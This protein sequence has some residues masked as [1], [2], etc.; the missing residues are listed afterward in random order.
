MKVFSQQLCRRLQ[1]VEALAGSSVH[2]CLEHQRT[3]PSQSLW[4]LE[5]NSVL[6]GGWGSPSFF[7]H[8]LLP[9]PVNRI[10]GQ[11][12]VHGGDIVW[13]RAESEA[14]SVF[15]CVSGFT[16]DFICIHYH[17]FSEAVTKMERGHISSKPIKLNV[18]SVDAFLRDTLGWKPN[19]AF[20]ISPI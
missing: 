17:H 20:L 12:L 6:I 3:T 13:P 18:M 9:L 11:F 5:T 8:N 14:L 10:Y 1:S 16:H 19:A 4:M 7:N 2:I 15:V